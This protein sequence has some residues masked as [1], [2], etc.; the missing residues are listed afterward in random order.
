[1][2]EQISD[3]TSLHSIILPSQITNPFKILCMQYT[4]KNYKLKNVSFK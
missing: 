4:K 2:F 1:M 3:Q